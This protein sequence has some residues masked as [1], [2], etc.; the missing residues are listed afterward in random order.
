VSDPGDLCIARPEGSLS[1]AQRIKKAF[2]Q[3]IFVGHAAND[4][5][6]ARGDIY[7]LVSV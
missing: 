4:F 6:D 3:K 2:L 1:H 7:V 5:D